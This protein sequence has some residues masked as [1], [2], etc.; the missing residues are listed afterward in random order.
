[1]NKKITLAEINSLNVR[2][3][4]RGMMANT[5]PSDMMNGLQR[6]ANEGT[7]SDFKC[8]VEV[9]RQSELFRAN[10]LSRYFIKK[11]SRPLELPI[12]NI[13]EITERINE[14]KSRILTLM[15]LATDCVFSITQK[16]YEAAF[17]T[18]DQLAKQGGV[19]IFLARLSYFLKNRCDNADL[20]HRIDL[21]LERIQ[22]GNI[23]YPQLAIRELSNPNTEY[24]NIREKIASSDETPMALIAKNL[25]D[26]VPRSL[27]QYTNILNAYFSVSLLDAF[28]YICSSARCHLFSTSHLLDVDLHR[29]FNNLS[30]QKLT[31][32]YSDS[33]DPGMDFFKDSTLLI[34]LDECFIYKT[35]HA[36]LYNNLEDKLFS[37]TPFENEILHD[38]F[39]RVE[40][41][42]DVKEFQDMSLT[43]DLEG[44]AAWFEKS[45]ALVYFLELKDGMIDDEV[46]F[47]ELMSC[48]RDIGIICP[49]R[50]LI[51]MNQD[52]KTNE[53]RLVAACLAYVKSRT[54]LNEHELREVIQDIAISEFDSDLV[55]LL[56]HLY[57]KSPAV[58]EHL[59]QILDETF[60]TKLF[61]MID[62]PN[63]AIEHRASILEWY[64]EKI[65]D[66]SYLDRAKNLRIDVQINKT[67]GTIDDSRIYVDPVK[68]TQWVTD[69]LLDKLSILAS[70]IC[71]K[72]EPS[73]VSV[74][75]DK[76]KSGISNTEQVSAILVTAYEEFCS[77]N[78]FGIASYIGRRIRHGTLKETGF[79]DIKLFPARQC[80]S[81]LFSSDEFDSCFSAWLRQYETCLVNLRD[82]HV[83][84]NDKRKPEGLISKE[85]RTAGKKITANHMLFEVL[86]SFNNNKNS[87]ELPYIITEY[88]WRLVEEDLAIIRAFIMDQKS[89][90]GVFRFEPSQDSTLRSRDIQDLVQE[91]NTMVAEKFRLIESWFNKPSIASPSAELSLLFK[92]VL[93]EIKGFFP[94]FQPIVIFDDI[95]Y[96]IRGGTYFVIYDALSI[97]IY[98]A[99]KYG[100]KDGEL[101]FGITIEEKSGGVNFKIIIS[102]EIEPHEDFADVKK[103][104]F[105]ALQGDFENALIF[106]NRS[107]IKKLKKMEQDL[108]IRNV[109][110]KFSEN[111]VTASFEFL[112]DYQS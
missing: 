41:L 27:E 42:H 9:L 6:I 1:M 52:G 102:S 74:S 101:H 85:F 56:E 15:A 11:F 87:Q 110:Y 18:L 95:E 97:I 12:Y 103:S 47:V 108:Q 65:V 39:S 20:S 64:G 29:S 40:N 57:E 66:A 25:I 44:A 35:S 96:V 84:I 77:N 99:A 75:W 3:I 68:F 72:G 89:K 58:T 13:T 76:V 88:C 86:K 78:K 104:I 21:L 62:R 83:Q 46:A 94:D 79:N 36:T 53:F 34:E 19:S 45:N 98:N 73:L 5:S 92:A 31:R 28:L 61:E 93:S 109:D 17:L 37:R 105:L 67:K 82:K 70:D 69:N 54:Q 106:E 60:L 59:I 50:Y 8:A 33:D 63:A 55:R 7:L 26:H 107:G 43:S 51:S 48:T 38:Y 24:L 10:D 90:Y 91:L 14:N 4:V 112:L 111:K 16:N 71:L 100:K 81:K 23:R 49:K 2:N 80:F 32:S 30:V 22:I